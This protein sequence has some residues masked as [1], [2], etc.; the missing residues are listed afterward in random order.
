MFSYVHSVES[1][2]I[3]RKLPC[4]ASGYRGYSP[5]NRWKMRYTRPMPASALKNPHYRRYFIASCFGTMGVWI[6]RFLFGWLIWEATE[7]FFWVGVASTSLLLPSLIVTPMAG[8]VSDRV[9]VKKGVIVWMA[10]QGVATFISW[11]VLHSFGLSLWPLL[12][13]T[14]LFGTVASAGSPLRLTLMPSLVTQDE[15]PNA[16][17]WGAMLFNTSRILG[18]ALA[19]AALTFFSAEML[20]IL[21][22]VSFTLAAF[23]NLGLPS[24]PRKSDT[25]KSNGWDSFLQGV[26]FSW[27]NPAIRTLLI[28]TLASSQVGRTFLELLPALSGILTG[29]TAQDLALLTAGAGVGSILGGW[30]ISRQ[31]GQGKRLIALVGSAMALSSLF[32]GLIIARPPLWAVVG[33]VA[34]ISGLMTIIGTGSQVILQLRI[35]EETRG[36]VMSLWLTLALAGPAV[37]ALVFGSLAEWVSE[38]AMLWV[39]ILISFASA[40]WLWQQRHTVLTTHD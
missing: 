1:R 21:C 16:V 34:T 11:G 15:L 8:V 40:I 14:V 35:P 5:K 27:N 25:K 22:G 29:G 39:M 17:G 18:P 10:A 37:G 7:S 13:M 33:L 19:A 6:T 23:I 36:R 12:I 30:V 9:D 31:R 38:A 26:R 32:L 20:F 4:L 24:I 28:L 2:A 3:V